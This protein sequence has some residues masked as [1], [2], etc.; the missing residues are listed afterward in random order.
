MSNVVRNSYKGHMLDWLTNGK[1][2]YLNFSGELTQSIS[3]CV[4]PR[5]EEIREMLVQMRTTFKWSQAYAA[6]V[7]GVPKA[8]VRAWERAERSPSGAARKLI[9]LLHTLFFKTA[10]IR[11]SRDISSWG[12]KFGKFNLERE[13]EE[14]SRELAGSQE[15][16]GTN[17]EPSN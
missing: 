12:G 4:A 7:F 9:W 13:L 6:A 3:T 11:N 5:P 10:P 1:D 14:L 16:G 15:T 8:T 17:S 2:Y